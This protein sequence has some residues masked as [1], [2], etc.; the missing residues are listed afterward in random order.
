MRRFL[1]VLALLAVVAGGLYGLTKGFMYYRVKST[2]DDLAEQT[3][4]QGDL[5]YGSIE[6]WITGRVAVHDLAFDPAGVD[7]AVKAAMVTVTGPDALFFVRPEELLGDESRQPM[8][9]RLHLSAAGVEVP[10]GMAGAGATEAQVDGC[11]GQPT[12]DPELLAALGLERI[13]MDVDMGWDYDAPAQRLDASFDVGL[14]GVQSVTG[15]VSLADVAPDAFEGTAA[16]MPQL[17]GFDLTFRFEPTFGERYLALCARRHGV[18]PE[19]FRRE[20]IGEQVAAVEAAGI[21]L[22][23]GLRLALDRFYTEWGEVRLTAW[24]GQPLGM[25]SLMFLPPERLT[26]TLGLTL[27]VNDAVIPDLSLTVAG[28]EQGAPGAALATLFGQ[29]PPK[30]AKQVVRKRYETRWVEVRPGGLVAYLDRDVRL[31]SAEQPPRE[32]RL[33][34]ISDGVAEVQQL[35]HGGKFTAYLPVAEVTRAEVE[36]RREIKQPVSGE[37]APARAE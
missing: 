29:A 31:H 9:P 22:G 14:A 3:R 26:D 7:G 15:E 11:R 18:A 36:V 20:L 17:R 32:G 35:I 28:S 19:A 6:T 37:T 21:R 24:P 16:S 25:L 12:A 2:L 1:I 10:L 5:S 4:L 34:G 8:P 30:Q 27:R 13:A 33:V 23:P